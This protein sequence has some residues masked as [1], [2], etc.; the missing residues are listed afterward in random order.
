MMKLG[1]NLKNT[2]RF[3]TGRKRILQKA[4]RISFADF[5]KLRPE[6]KNVN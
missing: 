6:R 1:K 2:C 3:S 4:A 5:P